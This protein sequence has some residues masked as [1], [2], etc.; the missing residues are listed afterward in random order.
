MLANRGHH[1][2]ITTISQ[3][4]AYAGGISALC[5]S[6]KRKQ[7]VSRGLSCSNWNWIALT[8]RIHQKVT[9]RRPSRGNDVIIT[10]SH[11]EAYAGGISALCVSNKRKQ[12]VSRGLLCSNWNWIALTTRIHQKVT[13][14]RPSRETTW[15]HACRQH[16]C[17]TRCCYMPW[18]MRVLNR[19]GR[20]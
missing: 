13:F 6:N 18:C 1:Y 3:P 11:P 4:E 2:V 9:F 10:F 7:H 20:Q 8:T 19:S 15:L 16:A 17:R 12:H 5:V 14:R